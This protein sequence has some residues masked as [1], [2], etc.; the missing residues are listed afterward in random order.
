[1]CP[2]DTLNNN[3]KN[4]IYEIKSTRILF[5]FIDTCHNDFIKSTNNN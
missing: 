1:M 2:P 5:C 4:N 3:N